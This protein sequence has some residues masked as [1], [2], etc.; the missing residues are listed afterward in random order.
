[1]IVLWLYMYPK[2]GEDSV[3]KLNIFALCSSKYGNAALEITPPNECAIILIF[4]SEFPG[5]Y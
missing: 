2:W 3:M 5:Q 4:P 1:M